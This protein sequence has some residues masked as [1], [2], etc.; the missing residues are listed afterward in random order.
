MRIV[1]E[2]GSKTDT[3]EISV[4]LRSIVNICTHI[5]MTFDRESAL[6]E[7]A[8]RFSDRIQVALGEL[9]VGL[10]VPGVIHGS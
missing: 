10:H 8:G 3:H 5:N 1:T 6:A 9:G 4:G 7:R 2:V